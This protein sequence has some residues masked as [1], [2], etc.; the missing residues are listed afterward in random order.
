MRGALTE[1]TLPVV[2]KSTCVYP[3]ERSFLATNWR[4]DMIE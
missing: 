2:I 3:S 1:A 4:C